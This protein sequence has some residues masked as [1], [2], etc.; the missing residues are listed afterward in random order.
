MQWC[1]VS[2]GRALA[3]RNQA[4]RGEQLGKSPLK[5]PLGK[6]IHGALPPCKHYAHRLVKSLALSS[7][8]MRHSGHHRDTLSCVASHLFSPHLSSPLSPSRVSISPKCE[9]QTLLCRTLGLRY[10]ATIKAP[11]PTLFGVARMSGGHN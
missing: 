4:M 8:L 5:S 10:G 3:S 6:L 11:I 2:A 1:K 7:G 9:P